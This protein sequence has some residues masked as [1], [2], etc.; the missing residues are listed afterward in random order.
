MAGLEVVTGGPPAIVDLAE[1]DILA[2]GNIVL[3]A[4]IRLVVGNIDLAAGR[5]DL[6]A[7]I[8]LVV[9]HVSNPVAEIVGM[10]VVGAIEDLAG[11]EDKTHWDPCWGDNVQISVFGGNLEADQVGL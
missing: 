2:V 7:G 11:R 5:T 8:D 6:V 10:V 3:V 4:D 1:G 9:A